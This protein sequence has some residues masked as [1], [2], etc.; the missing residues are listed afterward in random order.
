MEIGLAL[1]DELFFARSHRLA[2]IFRGPDIERLSHLLPSR[3]AP[4][5]YREAAIN[6]RYR[7]RSAD[8]CAG[9]LG[10]GFAALVVVA[11]FHRRQADAIGAFD[12][13][14]AAT[15][16]DVARRRHR[17]LLQTLNQLRGYQ[18]G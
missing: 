14:D 3:D 10:P 1:I 15:A 7:N 13:D 11:D 8:H 12:I 5:G 4:F 17:R 18:A 9:F 6:H 2:G 16:D